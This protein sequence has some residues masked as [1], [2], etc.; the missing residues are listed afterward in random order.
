MNAF[1][2]RVLNYKAAHEQMVYLTFLIARS[3]KKL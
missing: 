1:I 3:Y 2:E